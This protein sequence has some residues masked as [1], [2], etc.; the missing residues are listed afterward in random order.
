[1]QNWWQLFFQGC[2]ILLLSLGFIVAR[3]TDLPRILAYKALYKV[4]AVHT[5]WQT[6]SWLE[7]DSDHFRLRYRPEDADVAEIVLANAEAV[8][9]PA[10]EL[11]QH[12][13]GGRSLIIL[14]PDR[15][16]LARQFG[17]TASESAMGVYWNG[18]I[19]ILSPYEW[20]GS[21]DPDEIRRSFGTMGP[22]AHEYA[23]LLVD[24]KACGNYPRW[25]T[26]G[27]AQYVERQ[28][29]GFTMAGPVEV[30]SWYPLAHMDREF[31]NLPDQFLAYFQ[32][33]KAVDYL[34]GQWGL[35]SLQ[36]LLQCLAKGT[37]LDRAF[38]Q[39]LGVD[40]AEFEAAFIQ[41]AY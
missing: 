3:T 1:M 16:S 41:Q 8:Y 29:I 10:A 18:I 17:W 22:M 30:T 19:R 6:R 28:L 5:S 26:E 39:I 23:H 11:L 13:P 36:Q 40:L 27:I 4:S 35:S 32:S 15:D 33:L 14:H 21:S 31:D 9:E 34:V 25:L 12:K 20:A 7:K 38:Q 2:L 37:P 24:R